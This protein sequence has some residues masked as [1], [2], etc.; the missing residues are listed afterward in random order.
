MPKQS[1]RDTDAVWKTSAEAMPA[2]LPSA[3][4]LTDS[5]AADIRVQLFSHGQQPTSFLVP[6]VAESLLVL[7]LKGAACVEERPLGGRWK[8]YAVQA[9]DFFLTQTAAPYEMRWSCATSRKFD[10]M[11]VYLGQRLLD[12]AGQEFHGARAGPGVRLRDVSGERDAHLAALL[13]AML[14]E[15]SLQEANPGAMAIQGLGQALAVHLVRHYAED[16]DSKPR[17]HALPAHRLSRVLAFMEAKLAEHASLD[18]FAAIAGLS[19]YHFTRMF[20]RATGSAPM[21]YYRQ[22][23]MERAKTL[24]RT[25]DL[26]VADIGVQLG[27][28]GTSHFIQVF[29]KSAGMTPSA[30]RQA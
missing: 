30:Y 29:R 12:K 23:R 27:Y 26:S 15:L 24:L 8:Q 17:R 3:F 14:H 22:L 1:P 16:P 5:R 9:N 18:D 6:A 2:F 11:H 25:T 4:Q 7:V 20:T 13:R 21:Q 10:V 28:A 19:R